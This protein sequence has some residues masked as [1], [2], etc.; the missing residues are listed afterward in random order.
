MITWPKLSIPKK[1]SDLLHDTSALESTFNRFFFRMS[2]K[3]DV[4]MATLLK[5]ILIKTQ[6]KEEE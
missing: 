3:I 5:K 6:S 4:I 2:K 1:H